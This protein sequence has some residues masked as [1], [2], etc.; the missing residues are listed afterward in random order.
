MTQKVL[1]FGF[2][3][4]KMGESGKL[5]PGCGQIETV[6]TVMEWAKD[7]DYIHRNTNWNETD[8]YDAV[9]LFMDQRRKV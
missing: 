2:M 6:A 4:F 5:L 9:I 7:F 8:Y 3:C 1:T